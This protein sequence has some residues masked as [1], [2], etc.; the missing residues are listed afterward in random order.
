VSAGPLRE[1]PIAL[2]AAR[3]VRESFRQRSTK[4]FLGLSMIAVVAVIVIAHFASSSSDSTATLVVA[5]PLTAEREASFEAAGSALGTRLTV[6]S[7]ADDTAA[8]E[9]VADGDADVAILGAAGSWTLLTDDPVDLDDGSDLAGLVNVLRSGLALDNAIEQAGLTAAQADAVHEARL[10]AVD[11]VRPDRDDDG[12]GSRVALAL[13]MNV[14]LFLLLQ[15]YGGWIVQGVTRE[16]ASRVVEVLLSTMTPRQ[17]LIGKLAGIGVLA[18][19]H[20]VALVVSALVAA[21]AVGLDVLRG[22]RLADV[23]VGGVWFLL[24]YAL[25][26]SAFAAA[27]ALCGR[28]EDAQGA[29]LPLMLPLLGAYII[30]FS[31]AGGASTLLWVLAFLPPTAVLAMPALNAVGDVPA[32]AVVVSMA[33]TAAAAVLVALLAAR[34]YERSIL[35]SGK[36]VK[37]REAF[38]APS[39]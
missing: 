11:S 17:L 16:K 21:R 3:E 1:H 34:I 10:P 14:L 36:R 9:A 25:Y 39:E 32:W 20:A 2:V 5:G 19:I 7:V 26:C 35:R 23:A 28:S 8:R 15:S 37:W 18:L 27:G 4:V 29:V 30:S 6:S 22:F 24:G 31:A 12:R 13:V 38:S 33:A